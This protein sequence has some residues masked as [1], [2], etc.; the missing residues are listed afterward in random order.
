M[1]EEVTKQ[2]LHE[3]FDYIPIDKGRPLIFKYNIGMTRR[4]DPAGSLD[5]RGG[6]YSTD[7]LGKGYLIHRLVWLWKRPGVYAYSEMPKMLDHI[8]QNHRDNRY[9]NLR[10]VDGTTNNMNSRLDM[11]NRTS[12]YR[13]VSLKTERS[14][15]HKYYYWRAALA[16]KH[17]GTFPP[18]PKG[19]IDAALCYD[20]GVWK[21]YGNTTGMNFPE[22]KENYLGRDSEQLEFSFILTEPIQEHIPIFSS[23]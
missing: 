8:N 18:T 4:G 17:L 20:R 16:K 7:V 23:V 6:S 2:I 3:K 21:A 15:G 11:E 10:A 14:G 9:E 1:I 12:E 13:G 5:K 22:Q 19:E